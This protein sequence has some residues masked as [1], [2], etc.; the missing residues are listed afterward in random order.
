MKKI[1]TALRK[2]HF[3]AMVFWTL[4]SILVYSN[5]LVVLPT[6]VIDFLALPSYVLVIGLVIFA[7]LGA[8]LSYH[9][10]QNLTNIKAFMIHIIWSCI[11]PIIISAIGMIFFDDLYSFGGFM[12]GLEA[13]GLWLELIFDI[14]LEIIYG[15]VLTIWYCIKKKK[16][17]LSAVGQYDEN[18]KKAKFFDVLNLFSCIAII[19]LCLVLLA[20]IA[21]DF[22]NQKRYEMRESR[23]EK[24]AV[25]FYE[26]NPDMDEEELLVI[27]YTNAVVCEN[28]TIND[29]LMDEYMREMTEIAGDDAKLDSQAVA[30][31]EG[32]KH[33][34]KLLET[35]QLFEGVESIN[36]YVVYDSKNKCARCYYPF[37]LSDE[38]RTWDYWVVVSFDEDMNFTIDY[39][40]D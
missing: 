14:A 11:I 2:I 7:A 30:V 28:I 38:S 26:H 40:L 37:V 32:S 3:F 9:F 18:S 25:E 23:N 4:W 21:V 36:Q 16:G 22:I 33:L 15:I 29:D 39:V 19:I 35:Y 31:I 27:G 17:T 12:P 1:T 34:T 6:E 5:I 8:T 13:L 24:Y 20:S 10:L